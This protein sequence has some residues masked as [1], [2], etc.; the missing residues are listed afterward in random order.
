MEQK[1]YTPQEV[2]QRLGMD[3][4]SLS[5]R[6]KKGIIRSYQLSYNMIRYSEEQI[7]EY[8]ANPLSIKTS[9][10]KSKEA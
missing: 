10:T 4:A 5:R 2:A 7:Q 9:I 8:L 3:V 6:R 1:L